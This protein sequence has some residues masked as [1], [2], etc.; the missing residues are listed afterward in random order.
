VRA[1]TLISGLCGGSLR[2][3]REA[4]TTIVGSCAG[5]MSQL[6]LTTVV[7]SCEGSLRT[8]ARTVVV[9]SCAGQMQ[10]AITYANSYQARRRI[11]VPPSSVLGGANIPNF[12]MLVRETL[13]GLRSVAN[14]G[15]IQHASGFASR[16]RPASSWTTGSSSTTSPPASS[17]PGCASRP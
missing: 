13:T 12:V 1:I 16:P 8:R 11:I 10:D 14:G 3:V 17:S 4:L 7:G 2:S 6:A 15:R 5:A 9:G